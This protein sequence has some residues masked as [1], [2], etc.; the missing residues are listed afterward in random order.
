[1]RF[2]R[3]SRVRQLLGHRGPL[4]SPPSFD[5]LAHDKDYVVLDVVVNWAT[6]TGM[7]DSGEDGLVLCFLHIQVRFSLSL[8]TS[9]MKLSIQTG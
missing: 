5:K 3:L 1:V 4:A 8:S 9:N 7:Q 2:S 6:D